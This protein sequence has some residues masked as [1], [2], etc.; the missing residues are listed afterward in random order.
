MVFLTIA[1]ALWSNG[2]LSVET[3]F[4]SSI[5]FVLMALTGI[6]GRVHAPMLL[7]QRAAFLD[8]CLFRDLVLIGI[9][10]LVLC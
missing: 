8:S 3:L 4:K 6:V 7:A 9:T 5:F 2:C 1:M 10:T